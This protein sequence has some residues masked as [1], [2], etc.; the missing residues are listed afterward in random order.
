MNQAGGRT[1]LQSGTAGGQRAYVTG[2]KRTAVVK[3]VVFKRKNNRAREIC[4]Q[5]NGCGKP[6]TK[7]GDCLSAISGN[8]F[9]FGLLE[10]SGCVVAIKLMLSPRSATPT[11]NERRF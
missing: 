1:A 3:L 10:R 7:R 11:P 2:A 9:I 5:S 8:E 6:V 4:R